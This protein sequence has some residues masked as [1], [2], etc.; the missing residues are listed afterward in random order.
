MHSAT[1][2]SF[3]FPYLSLLLLAILRSI[4]SLKRNKLCRKY[5][6]VLS[7]CQVISKLFRVN[8]ESRNTALRCYR[9]HL[10]CHYKAKG[11]VEVNGTLHFN[12]ELNTL[13]IRG[14]EHFAHFAH[15]LWAHDRRSVGFLNIALEVTHKG[16]GLDL[17]DKQLDIPLLRQGI[18]RL[19]RIIFECDD[20]VG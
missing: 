7:E 12:P 4:V 10:P 18:F 1:N 13:E 20:G 11:R 16:H 3:E 17:P 6:V 19:K 2:I 8:S 9:V 15:D 14:T 5:F